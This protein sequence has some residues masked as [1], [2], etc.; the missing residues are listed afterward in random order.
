MLNLP[1]L[2]GKLSMGAECSGSRRIS[3]QNELNY[4]S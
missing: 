1:V 4:L 3:Q 2:V